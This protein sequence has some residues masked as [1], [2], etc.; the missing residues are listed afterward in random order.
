MWQEFIAAGKFDKPKQIKNLSEYIMNQQNRTYAHVVRAD[1]MDPMK[2]M[3]LDSNLE[4]PMAIH[5]RVGRPRIPW[6]HA[7]NKWLYEKDLGRGV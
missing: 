4:A 3:T 6:V 5:R 7:N 2:Q 1:M